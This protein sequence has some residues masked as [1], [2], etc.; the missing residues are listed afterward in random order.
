MRAHRAGAAPVPARNIT[1]YLSDGTNCVTFRLAD[2]QREIFGN[3]AIYLLRITDP[4]IDVPDAA[5]DF[6]KIRV[7][8]IPPE[9]RPPWSRV[10]RAGGPHTLTIHA[11][12]GRVIRTF[13]QVL[14]G[15]GQ[16]QAWVWDKQDRAAGS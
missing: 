11:P 13:P 2:T 15:R 9:A 8:P 12:D 14:L 4:T 1:S 5:L 7:R 16:R 3:T 6:Q 10:S